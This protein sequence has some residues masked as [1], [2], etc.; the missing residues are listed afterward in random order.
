L[1]HLL[2]D[3]ACDTR[4]ANLILRVR[5]DGL[6][7]DVRAVDPRQKP[8]GG[9]VHDHVAAGGRQAGRG[10]ECVVSLDRASGPS[11]TVTCSRVSAERLANGEEV[12]GRESPSVFACWTCS[13]PCNGCQLV[14]DRYTSSRRDNPVAVGRKFV[15]PVPRIQGDVRAVHVEQLRV[16]R[17][18]SVV[19][20]P[21]HDGARVRRAH[22]DGGIRACAAAV[23]PF[24][25]RPQ[26]AMVRVRARLTEG[27]TSALGR[28]R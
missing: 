14:S 25:P 4:R 11:C 15:L 22:V 24:H 2:R 8:R 3:T 28:S 10:R 9:A 6:L 13:Q 18:D 5:G 27:R 1:L 21:R 7:H 26:G 19:N 16:D 23:V 17:P 20:L 12:T